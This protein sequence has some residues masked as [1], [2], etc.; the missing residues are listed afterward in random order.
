MSKPETFEQE[1][2]CGDAAW[3]VDVGHYGPGKA[4]RADVMIGDPDGRSLAYVER[5]Q[6]QHLRDF[7]RALDRAADALE[8]AAE[9]E[10][11]AVHP[12]VLDLM[13]A[14]KESLRV[15]GPPKKGDG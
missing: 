2:P 14:L 9:P 15:A 12:P 6:A 13:E 4:L 10:P 5:A 8:A 3:G 7:A 1:G 11:V